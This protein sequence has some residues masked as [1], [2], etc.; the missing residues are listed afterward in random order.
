MIRITSELG[1]QIREKLN[2]INNKFGF[3]DTSSNLNPNTM[4]TEDELDYIVDLAISKNDI[5]YLGYFKNLECLDISLS[6][7]IDNNDFVYISNRY[8]NIIGLSIS[9]QNELTKIDLTNFKDLVNLIV[10]DNDNLSYV[11][12]INFCKKLYRI[13]MYNNKSLFNMNNI[14]DLLNFNDN[15]KICELDISYFVDSISYF[16][17]I[18]KPLKNFNL[19]NWIEATGFRYKNYMLYSNEEVYSLFKMVSDIISK[20]IYFNDGNVEKFGVCYQWFVNNFRFLNGDNYINDDNILKVFRTGYGSRLT[21]AKAFQ[22]LLSVVG[23]DSDMIYSVGALENIGVN[24]GVVLASLNGSSDYALLR[25]KIDGRHYYCDIAWDSLVK[26][27]DFYENLR[28]VLVSLDE[29]KIRHQIVSELHEGKS[30]TYHSNDTE[31]LI[32]FAQDRIDS[33]NNMILDIE[34]DKEKLND[35]E[36]KLVRIDDDLYELNHLDKEDLDIASKI[37]SI[38][39]EKNELESN[40]TKL[41]EKRKKKII[42]YKNDFLGNY[43][44]LAE[45]NISKKELNDRM[46]LL[47]NLN[48][49]GFISSYIYKLISLSLEDTK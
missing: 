13:S 24:N 19:I 29:L 7:S 3:L 2:N 14:Y 20:Y 23:I 17:K 42:K 37:D 33:V 39:G 45:N 27:Q 41:N 16:R 9:N 47:N 25:V 18:N 15:I 11:D 6:P 34:K 36:Y 5:K 40:M 32:V 38:N 44:G 46:K 43:L 22:F 4:F 26:D 8:N 21:Y 1:K 10:K 49:Y 48:N 28:L 12:N 31:N 30:S 35:I